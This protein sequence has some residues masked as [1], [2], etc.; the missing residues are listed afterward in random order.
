[1]PFLRRGNDNF[2]N[3]Y[4]SVRPRAH[5]P[6][7]GRRRGTSAT[8]SSDCC[9]RR[10]TPRGLAVPPNHDVVIK[11]RP[12]VSELAERRGP[13]GRAGERWSNCWTRRAW[14]GERVNRPKTHRLRRRVPRQIA[15]VRS[16]PTSV[17]LAG[18]SRRCKYEPTCSG[19]AVGDQAVR[20]TPRPR[21]R[22]VAA[23][24]LQ[25][26]QPWWPRSGR[27]PAPVPT[28]TAGRPHC[29]HPACPVLAN[30]FQ[31]L[32]DFFESVLSG[33]TTRSASAGACDHRA[34]RRRPRRAVR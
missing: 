33:S 13:R 26:V 16:A 18:V 32:I 11:A 10:S 24:S 22:R 27:G 2:Q 21:A 15:I 5:G 19:Y 8:R 14:P 6:A 34:D 17:H 1:M 3:F 28:P 23:A 25:P 31:P 29:A 7:Q 12:D 4:F 30:I 20:H 9:A